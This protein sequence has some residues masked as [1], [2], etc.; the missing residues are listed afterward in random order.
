MPRLSKPKRPAYRAKKPKAK[1]SSDYKFYNSKAWR[2]YSRRFRYTCEI[3]TAEGQHRDITPSSGNRGVVDHIV[4][5]QQGGAKWDKRNHMGMCGHHH[6]KKRGLDSHGYIV[7]A[8]DTA[9]G[10]IP[11]DR[12]EIILKLLTTK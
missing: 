7:R 8:T 2:D 1:L 12:Q 9:A 6:D 10:F 11:E 5:V 4:P 3:C